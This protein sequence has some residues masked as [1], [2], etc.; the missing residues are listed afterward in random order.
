M[1]NVLRYGTTPAEKLASENQMCRQMVQEISTIGVTQR[2]QMML[3][4]LLAMELEDIEAMKSITSLVKEL[5]GDKLF[6][7]QEEGGVDG[8]SNV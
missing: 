5:N 1:N 2:Q 3:I 6:L 7:A 8:S 4:Y